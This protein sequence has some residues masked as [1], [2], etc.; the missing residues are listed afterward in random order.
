MKRSGSADV[1]TLAV[2]GSVVPLV[3]GHA[4]TRKRWTANLA[5]FADTARIKQDGPPHC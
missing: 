1:K 2:A 5:T 3:E 4:D